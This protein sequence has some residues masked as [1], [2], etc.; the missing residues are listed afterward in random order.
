MYPCLNAC[1]SKNRATLPMS[2]SIEFSLSFFAWSP[3]KYLL[4]TTLIAKEDQKSGLLTLG[5]VNITFPESSLTLTS[6]ANHLIGFPYI[7]NSN[8][9]FP[10]FVKNLSILKTPSSLVPD[11]GSYLFQSTLSILFMLLVIS[12]FLNPLFPLF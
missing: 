2:C 11:C 8:G 12:I 3:Q 9:L 10:S 4:A 1:L 7:S 5:C 6:F